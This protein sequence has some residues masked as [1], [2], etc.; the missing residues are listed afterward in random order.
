M[1]EIINP[2]LT[3]KACPHASVGPGRFGICLGEQCAVWT[4]QGCSF[5]VTAVALHNID[6]KLTETRNGNKGV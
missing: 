1:S 3:R 6:V 4:P 5:V 2:A